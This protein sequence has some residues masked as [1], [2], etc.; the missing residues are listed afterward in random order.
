[1]QR[2]ADDIGWPDTELFKEVAPGSRI[3]GNATRSNVFQGGPKAA[4]VSEHQLMSD[5]K[6][7][8]PALLGK[9]ISGGVGEHTDELCSLSPGEAIDKSWLCSHIR[10]PNS[11][12]DKIVCGCM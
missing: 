9:I 4:S 1:M 2:V 12:D 7:F 8:N 3:V 6:V 5:A 11:A 10:L